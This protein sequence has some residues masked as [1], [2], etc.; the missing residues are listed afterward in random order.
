MVNVPDEDVAAGPSVSHAP[1]RSSP[2]RSPRARASSCRRATSRRCSSRSWRSRSGASARAS[3]RSADLAGRDRRRDRRG[4]REPRAV[5]RRGEILELRRRGRSRARRTTPSSCSTRPRPAAGCRSTRSKVDALACHSYKWLCSPAR[6]R[7]H[8]RRRR[9]ARPDPA[10][11]RQL[12]GRARPVRDVLRDAA[13]AGRLARGGS[14]SRPPGS[15]GS[16]PRRAIE[17]LLDIGIET[18]RDHDVGLANRFRTGLGLEPGDTA[19]VSTSVAGADEA[20]ARAGI[21]AAVRAGSLR[22]SFHVYTTEHGRGRRARG[23]RRVN[24]EERRYYDLRAPEY[25]DWYL[26]DGPFADR[27]RPGWDEETAPARRGRRG[28]PGRARAG[29]RLRHRVPDAAPARRGDRARPE[30]RDARA[31]RASGGRTPSSC[32]GD[33]PRAPVPRWRVRPGLHGALLRPPARGRP[34]AVPRRGPQGGA[35]ARGRR[36]GA[37][38]GHRAPR[39][40]RSGRSATARAIAS[41]SA[42]SRPRAWPRRSAARRS[43]PATGTSPPRRDRAPF[44]PYESVISSLAAVVPSSSQTLNECVAALLALRT[45]AQSATSQRPGAAVQD[46]DRIPLLRPG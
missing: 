13:P 45:P 18:I 10:R 12:V 35:A 1:R 5:R 38:A 17:T 3:S 21:M 4:G 7:L 43:S 41:T 36:H 8:D 26:G 42:R 27:D 29:R 30:R 24:R 20:F 44:A 37:R 28:P 23:A 2:R 39:R 6:H 15:R 25:D 11:R 34:H 14:T 16:G 22:A 33:A 9:P 40:C 32:V 19:I 46:V 31:R